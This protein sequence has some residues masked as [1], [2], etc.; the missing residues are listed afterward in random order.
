[1]AQMEHSAWTGRMDLDGS[2]FAIA[3]TRD[4]YLWVGTTSGLYRFDGVR[5]K[6]WD[7]GGD[8]LPS[9]NVST[10][11]ATPDGGLW[12]GFLQGGAAFYQRWPGS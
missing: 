6:L 8:Q 3:Q 1:M 5:F 12:V 11:M 7:G 10:L 2:V 9:R 4:R